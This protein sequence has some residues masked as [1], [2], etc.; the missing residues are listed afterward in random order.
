M[1]NTISDLP[2]DSSAPDAPDHNALLQ[3]VQ[4]D[5]VLTKTSSATNS[6]ELPANGL[7]YD[8]DDVDP[9]TASSLGMR[10]SELRKGPAVLAEPDTPPADKI[11]LSSSPSILSSN[12]VPEVPMENLVMPEASSLDIQIISNSIRQP[13]PDVS[14]NAELSALPLDTDKDDSDIELSLA[15]PLVKHTQSSAS[16]M[17]RHIKTISGIAPDIR[18]DRGRNSGESPR[19][20]SAQQIRQ[21]SRIT[22]TRSQTGPMAISPPDVLN[23]IR[24]PDMSGGMLQSHDDDRASQ[25]SDNSSSS[26][27]KSTTSEDRRRYFGPQSP[28]LR[29]SVT[30]STLKRKAS[31]VRTRNTISQRTISDAKDDSNKHSPHSSA[32]EC[33]NLMA[34]RIKR[35]FMRSNKTSLQ[36]N[37]TPSSAQPQLSSS[38]NKPSSTQQHSFV[39]ASPNAIRV[40]TL[41]VSNLHEQMTTPTIAP[42]GKTTATQITTSSDISPHQLR[43]SDG[44]ARQSPAPNV[45]STTAL[46]VVELKHN[47]FNE[48]DKQQIL[49]LPTTCETIFEE[50]QKAYPD[51]AGDLKHFQTMCRKIEA[52]FRADKPI[53]QSLYDDFIIR[54]KTKYATYASG[55]TEM[56]EDP[57]PYET[58][59]HNEVLVPAY[60]KLI[61]TQATLPEALPRQNHT[62]ISGKQSFNS[63]T[64]T[65]PNEPHMSASRVVDPIAG[66]DGR[67][68]EG[69]SIGTGRTWDYNGAAIQ[70]RNNRADEQFPR[71][72]NNWET[73][74]RPSHASNFRQSTHD[75]DHR[76][77]SDQWQHNRQS[78]YP[79][80][81]HYNYVDR[82]EDATTGRQSPSYPSSRFVRTSDGRDWEDHAYA[83]YP[84]GHASRP[85]LNSARNSFTSRRRSRSPTGRNHSH[86]TSFGGRSQIEYRKPPGSGRGRIDE[87][88]APLWDSHDRRAASY[89]DPPRSGALE[90][91]T[92]NVPHSPQQTTAKPLSSRAAPKTVGTSSGSSNKVPRRSILPWQR[93]SDN[94]RKHNYDADATRVLNSDSSYDKDHRWQDTRQWDRDRRY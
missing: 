55:C 72:R 53:H 26:S 23:A 88:F 9:L 46:A 85:G 94:S 83:D 66:W 8:L 47:N 38:N 44:V 42:Q 49:P 3:Q 35:D 81:E 14:R 18:H 67:R 68:V 41:G 40:P 5:P 75:H 29:P 48:F 92:K 74:P 51:Y 43:L 52:L 59:Y 7:V 11:A 61:I 31:A 32:D 70:P 24:D 36:V 54:Q 16:F 17:T 69:V 13:T 73:S 33:A 12:R 63:S 62:E 56:G 19:S 60:T 30:T 15:L 86:S 93:S 39:T 87:D 34:R 6:A 20:N 79:R 28:L 91:T 78:F 89:P 90:S 1:I 80:D 65:P 50:F 2:P 21:R 45:I 82:W 64:W 71:S 77:S 37:A 76:D 10:S 27:V 58:Y 57:V 4:D 84:Q 22:T 25:K